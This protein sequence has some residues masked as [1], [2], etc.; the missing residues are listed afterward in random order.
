MTKGS[1]VSVNV[2]ARKCC[3]LKHKE[4]EGWS[5]SGG[6]R[7]VGDWL[8]QALKH[9]CPAARGV[10]ARKICHGERHGI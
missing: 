9:P 3:E 8:L 1:Q 2:K 6:T 5:G 4:N 7:V 10:H